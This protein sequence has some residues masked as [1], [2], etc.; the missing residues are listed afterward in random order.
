MKD[1][2]PRNKAAGY[3]GLVLMILGVIGVILSEGIGL[4]DF[5]IIAVC[6]YVFYR[7]LIKKA[8]LSR[9][10][11]I[12]FIAVIAIVAVSF[13]IGLWYAMMVASSLQV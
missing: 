9:I 2:G 12:L 1:I 5:V 4:L 3:A 10:E 8:K 7:T 6:A 11:W 13:V